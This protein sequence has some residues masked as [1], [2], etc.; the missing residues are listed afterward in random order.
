MRP[1]TF[2]CGLKFRNLSS[3]ALCVCLQTTEITMFCDA[4]DRRLSSLKPSEWL[5]ARPTAVRMMGVPVLRGDASVS[6]V[7]P[8]TKRFPTCKAYSSS[9]CFSVLVT[10]QPSPKQR[11]TKSYFQRP[12]QKACSSKI[13]CEMLWMLLKW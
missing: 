6:S 4:A 2:D 10:I 8:Q 11:I 12:V 1:L 7:R 9:I 3:L 13:F 5:D